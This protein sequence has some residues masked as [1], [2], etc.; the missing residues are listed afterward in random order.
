MNDFLDCELSKYS[1]SGATSLH[2]AHYSDIMLA[3]QHPHAVV[4]HAGTNDICGRNR[5]DA[6]AQQIANDIINIGKRCKTGGVV[7]VYISSLLITNNASA[8]T[9]GKDI[10]TIL[11]TLCSEN[12]YFFINNDFLDTNHLEDAVH[13]TWEGRRDLVNNYIQ[14]LNN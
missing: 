11:N 5:R 9:K 8:N 14:I 4:I 13:L 12:N 1:Y 2:L 6:S 10:N 7:N 3:E